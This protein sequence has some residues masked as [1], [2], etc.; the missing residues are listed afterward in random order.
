MAKAKRQEQNQSGVYEGTPVEARETGSGGGQTIRDVMSRDV[1]LVS[2]DMGI[3]EVAEKMASHDIGC[4]PVCDGERLIGMITDRDITVRVVGG[5]R[6][7][8]S[9]TVRDAMSEGIA[10]CFEDDDVG[11]AARLMEQKQIRRLPILNREKR[12]VGI[13]SLGDVAVKGSTQTAGEALRSTGPRA[14]KR[15]G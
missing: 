4:I 11:A 7:P 2:P 3:V 6:D 5:R 1:E 13:V 12:L 9:C 10:Y 15:A 14:W 8:S